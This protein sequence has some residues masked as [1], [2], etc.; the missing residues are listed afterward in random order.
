MTH[1]PLPNRLAALALALADAQIAAARDVTGLSASACAALTTIAQ[2]PGDSIGAL[3]RVLDLTHSVTVRLVDQLAADGLVTKGPGREDRRAVSLT[4]TAAGRTMAD[5]IRRARADAVT[6]ALAGLDPAGRGHLA[7]A[8]DQV[9]AAVTTGRLQ[10][11]HL[12]RLCD[13]QAC[14][15]DACPVECRAIALETGSGS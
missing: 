8:V 11:D 1:D 12:C 15:G 7:W 3:A 10:A 4:L 14:G 13:E 2:Y 5:G 6:R 9:L